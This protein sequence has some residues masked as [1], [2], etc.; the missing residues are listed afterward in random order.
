MGVYCTP[1]DGGGA[2]SET[3]DLSRRAEYGQGTTRQSART[4]FP[5]LEVREAYTSGIITKRL[6]ARGIVKDNPVDALLRMRT[7]G[8]THIFIQPTFI[9][10]GVEMDTLL[11]A[12]ESVKKFFTDIKV[13]TP[14]LYEVDDAQK[15]VDILARRHPADNKRN[16]HMLLIG[17]GTS[18]PATAI[19]SEIDYMAKAAGHPNMHCATIEGYP[20]LQD[21]IR[22]LK[23][24][25]AK[26][27]TLV[28]FLFVAGNHATKDISKEWKE[29]MERQGFITDV[30]IEGLG[31]VPEIQQLYIEKIERLMK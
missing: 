28:P 3:D 6:K 18:T 17:H 26:K 9:I 5:E 11:H 24:G 19:Y 20:T 21:A 1:A 13:G 23:M 25:K 10:D 30:H 7:E 8:F 15:V 2:K 27:L 29:E 4:T 16:E 14:L 31:E 22:M 12:V